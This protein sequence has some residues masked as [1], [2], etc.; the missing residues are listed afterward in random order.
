MDSASVLLCLHQIT[1]LSY[2]S[3][4][5]ALEKASIKPGTSKGVSTEITFEDASAISIPSDLNMS[6][7][8]EHVDKEK[9]PQHWT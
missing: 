5:C 7:S 6:I 3:L 9:V 8:G 2:N 4:I 1:I